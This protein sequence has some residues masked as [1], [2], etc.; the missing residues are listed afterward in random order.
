MHKTTRTWR[1][2]LRLDPA[3]EAYSAPQDSLASEEGASCHPRPKASPAVGPLG[4]ER[5]ALRASHFGPRI[6]MTD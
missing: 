1:P 2:G 6:L 5:P 4:L 3:R